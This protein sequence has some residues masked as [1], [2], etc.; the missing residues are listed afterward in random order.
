MALV[1]SSVSS[2]EFCFS[3]KVTDF[4]QSSPP[5][6]VGEV[7]WR[8][9]FSRKKCIDKNVGTFNV[10]LS[11]DYEREKD[12]WIEAEGHLKILSSKED[13]KPIEMNMQSKKYMS[14]SRM[15]ECDFI[16]Y[17]DFISPENGF[18]REYAF[19]VECTITSRPL[20][21]QPLLLFNTVK[22]SSQQIIMRI[23]E[24]NNHFVKL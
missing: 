20:I 1:K 10:S 3:M 21:R 8:I 7:P 4:E 5:L 14:S 15:S 19:S 9:F 22:C 18:V 2:S 16:P 6:M 23:D 11:C 12:W 24:V 13:K 17:E